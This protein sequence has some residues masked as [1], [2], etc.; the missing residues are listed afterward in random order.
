MGHPGPRKSSLILAIARYFS[1]NIYKLDISRVTKSSLSSLFNELPS[2]SILLL[3]DINTVDMARTQHAVKENEA[4][5]NKEKKVSLSALLNALD[6][7]ASQEGRILIMTTNQPEKLDPALTRP[8]RVDKA[9]E[10][11]LATKS[12]ASQLFSVIYELSDCETIAKEEAVDGAVLETLAADFAIEMPE[13]EFSPGQI[14]SFLE[15]RRHSPRRAMRDLQPWI[16]RI[17]DGKTKCGG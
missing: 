17:R 10:L 8:G 13:G 7:V 4:D 14:M 6:G 2:T 12:V 11:G 15:E 9:I 5:T 1:L 3:E 16:T